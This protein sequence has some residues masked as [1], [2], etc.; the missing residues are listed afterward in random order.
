M[1][2]NSY[3]DFTS[4]AEGDTSTEHGMDQ[5]VGCFRVGIGDLRLS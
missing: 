4:I 2:Y 5:H 1:Q 3:D